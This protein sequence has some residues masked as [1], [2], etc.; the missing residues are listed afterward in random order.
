[1]EVR[2]TFLWCFE[3]LC[4]LL[5]PKRHNFVSFSNEEAVTDDGH[6]KPKQQK[7]GKPKDQGEV[8]V[9]MNLGTQKENRNQSL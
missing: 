2:L 5:K 3:G 9:E 6:V 7:H 4:F 8:L 1:M